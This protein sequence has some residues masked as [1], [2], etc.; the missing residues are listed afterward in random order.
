MLLKTSISELTTNNLEC[1]KNYNSTG[2]KLIKYSFTAG[3]NAFDLAKMEAI[4][5]YLKKP[6]L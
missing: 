5:I 2:F 1:G 3:S 6:K 4:L